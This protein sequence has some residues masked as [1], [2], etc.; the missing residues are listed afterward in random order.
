MHLSA[1]TLWDLRPASCFPKATVLKCRAPP[2]P[3][4]PTQPFLVPPSL[5]QACVSASFGSLPAPHPPQGFPHQSEQYISCGERGG[6]TLVAAGFLGSSGEVF[7]LY[8]LPLGGRMVGWKA[9]GWWSVRGYCG[10]GQESCCCCWWVTDSAGEM[11][12][13]VAALAGPSYGPEVR[14]KPGSRLSGRP[15]FPHLESSF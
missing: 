11:L 14:R 7:M 12:S 13:W 15:A 5:G 8:E 4:G 10:C 6:F 1:A 3:P 9:G 2:P